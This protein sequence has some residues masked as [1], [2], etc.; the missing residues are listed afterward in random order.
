VL[1]LPSFNADRGPFGVAPETFERATRL[2]ARLPR[3][4]GAFLAVFDGAELRLQCLAGR[5]TPSPDVGTHFGSA[6]D[7][8]AAIA[9]FVMV[10]D[11]STETWPDRHP[12]VH[13]FSAESFL[14]APLASSDGTIWGCLCVFDVARRSWSVDDMELLVE[15]SSS[16]A[17]AIELRLLKRTLIETDPPAQGAPTA[18]PSE[19]G[20][21]A[22]AAPAGQRPVGDL[23]K[24]IAVAS[25]EATTRM[26]VLQ[27]CVDTVCEHTGWLV[28]HA[29]LVSCGRL[30]PASLWHF[31][32]AEKY[33]LFREASEVA[34]LG[35]D[36]G[37]IGTALGTGEATWSV[38]LAAS[39]PYLRATVARRAGLRSGI[40]LPVLVQDEVVAVLEFYSDESRR[41]TEQRLALM[42]DVAAQLGR[43]FERERARNMLEEHAE[44]V[45]AKALTDELTGLHN[46]RG[47]FEEGPER[48]RVAHRDGRH[49]ALFFVDLNGMKLIND[50]FGHEYGDRALVDTADLLREGF[51]GGD[52]LARLGGDEFAVFASDVSLDELRALASRLQGQIDALNASHRRPYRL[53]AS[54]GAAIYADGETASFEELLSRADTLMYAEKRR[55]AETDARRAP[56]R[57][58]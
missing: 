26:Q 35:S 4:A 30:V 34:A 23:L 47:F 40:A 50:Q 11:V 20:G 29:Y 8:T 33:Q 25:N 42:A 5:H 55:R 41:P 51:R 57:V 31:A 32:D 36:R 18:R 16:I 27:S 44:Q 2:A 3:A 43:V 48:L 10:R 24:V 49:I 12:A 53:S 13:E 45:R 19:I 46:R 6:D 7:I 58:M 15:L 28:G 14:S 22:D 37:L 56:Q 9:P 1:A 52:L 17:A 39:L 21:N 54:V 38:D